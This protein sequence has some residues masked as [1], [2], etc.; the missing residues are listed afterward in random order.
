MRRLKTCINRMKH[1]STNRLQIEI[2]RHQDKNTDLLLVLLTHSY[3]QVINS[4]I[5]NNCIERQS[6]K[7][8]FLLGS[9]NNHIKNTSKTLRIIITP[10]PPLRFVARLRALIRIHYNLPRIKRN[11]QTI[12]SNWIILAVHLRIRH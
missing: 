1:P 8:F 9:L 4:R 10:P 2:P 11:L 7:H 6:H 3:N 12:I 5:G